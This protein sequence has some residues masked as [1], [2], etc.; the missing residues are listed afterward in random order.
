MVES[1]GFVVGISMTCIVLSEIQ[2]LPVWAAMLLFPVVDRL[3]NHCLSN[4]HDPFSRFAVE[5]NKFN[6]FLNN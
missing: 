3:R 1:V 6:V 2:V 4:R 5:K